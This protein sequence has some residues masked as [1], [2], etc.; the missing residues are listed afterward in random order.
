MYQHQVRDFLLWLES[1]GI[2]TIKKITS[3]DMVSYLDYL[4]SR[5]NRKKTGTL[6]NSTIRGNLISISMFF[7]HLLEANEIDSVIQLPRFNRSHY[8]NPRQIL[9]QEEVNI[10]YNHCE[11]QLE[12]AILSIAYGCGLRRTEIEQLDMKDIKLFEGII[13]VRSG[14]NE[15]RREVPMSNNV[16][17]HLKNYIQKERMN[18]LKNV[19]MM[20][21]ALLVNKNGERLS[22]DLI[23]KRLKAIIQRTG[24]TAI[25]NK[26]ITLHCLRHS[27]ATHLLENGAGIEFVSKFL[28]HANMDTS[29]LY[30]IRRKRE[31][32]QLIS[33]KLPKH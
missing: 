21:P 1:R 2:T 3:F 30:A 5:P 23:N 22:G 7:N 19:R 32:K 4:S 9:T 29:H 25:C 24:N 13:V 28:G 11:T 17:Q 27:I 16:L 18:Y 6:S 33:H 15:K 20:E 10:L 8:D 12:T 31:M 26:N 14:K